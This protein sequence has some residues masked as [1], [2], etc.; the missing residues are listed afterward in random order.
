MGGAD[1]VPGVSGGTIA[2][3]TGIYEELINTINQVSFDSIKLLFQGQFKTFWNQIN[4]N[5][6]LVLVGGIVI[7]FFSLAKLMTF[8]L[9]H[10]P[11]LLWS[12]FFGLIIASAWLIAKDLKPFKLSYLLS[13][14]LGAGISFWITTIAPNDASDN[15]FYLFFCGMLAFCAMILPG[16]SGSFILLLLGA[17]STMIG[18][19]SNLTEN[20]KENV[21]TIG[22]LA[23]GGVTGLLIFSRLLKWLFQQYKNLTIA[24]MTGFLLGSLNK[25]WP[26]QH[27]N[28]VYPKNCGDADEELVVISW[29]N[30]MPASYDIPIF[31]NCEIIEYSPA[32]SQLSGAIFFCLVGFLTIFLLE[33]LGKKLS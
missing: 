28:E 16:I 13:I 22:T 20:F 6:L 15:L 33:R 8:L 23:I 19:V 4:G 27:I 31:K 32:D 24:L 10:H 21:I 7:S 3:I 12:F 29:E 18:A 26:W 11:L 2:L 9:E 30:V 5:F 25:I 1:V 17:Y 14:L